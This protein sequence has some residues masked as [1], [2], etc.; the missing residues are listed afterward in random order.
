MNIKGNGHYTK[1]FDCIKKVLFF[2]THCRI[3]LG[4]Q[5]SD[6]VAPALIFFPIIPGRLNCGFAGIMTCRLSGPASEITADRTLAGLW[7][8]CSVSGLKPVLEG[9]KS[10]GFYLDGAKTLQTLNEAVG[11]LKCDDAQALLFFQAERAKALSCLADDMKQFLAGEENLLEDRT[12]ALN[13]ADL[14]TINS[15]LVELKDICWILEKDVLANLQ[16]VLALSGAETASSLAPAA[17]HKYRKLNLLLNALDRLE[18]R[19]RDSAGIQLSFVVKNTEDLDAILQRLRDNG[20][21]EAYEQRSR[22]GDLLNAS[23]DVSRPS[24]DAARVCVTF[25]YKTFSI[26]G[27]LGR[28]VFELRRFIQQDRIL[29]FFAASDAL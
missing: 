1:M 12:V 16:R 14:E 28:N 26:V 10:V 29:H 3:Y 9:Q 13:S 17:F 7:K 23:I 19:G 18:V 11:L 20:C 6:A 5:P 4:R 8:K 15:R 27:E 22:K 25:T 24:R 2:V 21:L